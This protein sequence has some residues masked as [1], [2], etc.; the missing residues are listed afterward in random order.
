ML[1]NQVE[2]ALK[3]TAFKSHTP[4]SIYQFDPIWILWEI[5]KTSH[6]QIFLIV[7]WYNGKNQ[8]RKWPAEKKWG[9]PSIQQ[10]YLRTKLT[11]KSSALYFVVFDSVRA[12]E[13][14]DVARAWLMNSVRNWHAQQQWVRTSLKTFANSLNMQKHWI[15]K[16]CLG[17]ELWRVRLVDKSTEHDKPHFDFYTCVFT[18]ISTPK[19]VLF[20]RARA[21]KGIAHWHFWL[22]RSE[23]AYAGYPGS[24]F[25]P[26]RVHAE[27][28]ESWGTGLACLMNSMRTRDAQ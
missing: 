18:T 8:K 6:V 12:L 24:L 19:K 14:P 4:I 3:I 21:E 11:H 28:K 22:V 25:S 13:M 10:K 20:F 5:I 23:H 1:L 26:A 2:L 16:K 9:S 27:R 7:F 15:R 17:K